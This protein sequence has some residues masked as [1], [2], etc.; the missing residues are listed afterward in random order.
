MRMPFGVT[1]RIARVV[2]PLFLLFLAVACFA[3]LFWGGWIP[4]NEER[5]GNFY[6]LSVFFSRALHNGTG[7]LWDPYYYGG[8]PAFA[9]LS[10]GFLS[11][12]H[13]WIFSTLPP[14]SA[15]FLIECFGVA[16]GLLAGYFFGRYQG[17]SIRA[18]LLLTISFLLSRSYDGLTMGLFS[19]YD[20]LLLPLL[21]LVLTAL[22]RPQKKPIFVGF[23]IVGV[24]G[25]TA[26]LIGGHPQMQLYTLLLGAV[27]ALIFDS[28]FSMTGERWWQR[29]RSTIA[30]VFLVVCGGLLATPQLIHSYSIGQLSVRTTAYSA[31][32][33]SPTP[34]T[35]IVSYLLPPAIH[36]PFVTGQIFGAYIGTLGFFFALV[37][38][39]FFRNRLVRLF[40][41]SY[42]IILAV[43]LRLP[44]FAT[45]H[46]HLPILG[47]TS[48]T[49]RFLALGAFF[50]CFLA[51]YGY[52]RL[53]ETGATWE[54]EKAFQKM[55]RWSWCAVG[56]FLITSFSTMAVLFFLKTNTHAQDW[57][58]TL[59]TKNRSLTLP[60]AHYRTVFSDLLERAATTIA[61]T[62][63]FF[64][65]SLLL[66]P[67]ALWL[68]SQVRQTPRAR[69]IHAAILLVLIINAGTTF[70]AE[71]PRLLIPRHEQ[72]KMPQIVG[73]IR[74]HESDLSSFRI[75]PILTAEGLFLETPKNRRLTT[76]DRARYSRETL[77]GELGSVYGISTMQGIEPLRSLRQH[78]LVDTVLAPH[79]RSIVDREAL[80]AWAEAPEEQA[81]PSA[82]LVSP[83]EK[84]QH[85]LSQLDLLSLLNVK[86]L[87]TPHRIDDVRLEEIPLAPD[88]ELP[89][90][91]HLY[92]NASVGPRIFFAEQ[93]RF[94]D[95]NER[96]LLRAIA[97]VKSGGWDALIECADC[98]AVPANGGVGTITIE[99]ETPGDLVL[100][101]NRDTDGWLVVHQT[102]FP[103]WQ[104]TLDGEPIPIRRANYLFQA[105]HVPP[106]MHEIHLTYENIFQETVRQWFLDPL[107]L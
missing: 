86:Y 50:F 35:N 89:L 99:R 57:L 42:L 80:A 51:A 84:I 22:R 72:E 23:F 69:W 94:W 58:F 5:M 9:D 95:G 6:P 104:A 16:V 30:Y 36:I 10:G 3:P 61:P 55:M 65:I 39:F 27:L 88:P 20:F 102:F 38:I 107:S 85:F 96:E 100:K 82:R 93:P 98:T 8:F 43:S 68:I 15:H 106:G 76:I 12:L 53:S 26:G 87:I 33:A 11:P 91:L 73:V 56:V 71:F 70:A 75:L 78:L 105:V 52:D 83:E 60:L 103:G 7:F 1:P 48:G 92:K 66:I 2:A 97:Q 24:L 54:K 64:V 79:L 101:T 14:F 90:P 17:L 19:G 18:S 67:V 37:A 28:A 44:V 63:P 62:N 31:A 41:W 21:A 29:L 34:L 32:A 25:M 13:Q 46:D 4:F 74:E 47:R 45:V 59:L 40:S 77:V 49:G 81:F